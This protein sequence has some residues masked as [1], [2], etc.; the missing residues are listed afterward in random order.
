MQTNFNPSMSNNQINFK[1]LKKVNGIQYLEQLTEEGASIGNNIISNLKSKDSFKTLCEK[2]DVFVTLM[3]QCKP[4]GL[5]LKKGLLLE[6][7]AQKINKSFL[8][9][10]KKKEKLP[11]ARFMPFGTETPTWKLAEYMNDNYI[12]AKDGLEVDIKEFL[13]NNS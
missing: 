6:I 1:S 11:V 7:F 12:N 5:L 2:Y 4:E 8:G 9:L 10:F 13:R 3:P